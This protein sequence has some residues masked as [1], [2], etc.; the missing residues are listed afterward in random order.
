[1]SHE[2][3]HFTMGMWVFFLAYGTSVVGSYVGLSCVRQSFKDDRKNARIR[4]LAMASLAIGGVGIWLMHFIGMMGFAVPGST[5][6][7]AL[8]PTLFSVVLAVGATL[9]GL[10]IVDSRAGWKARVPRGVPL[11]VGGLVMG[12]AVSFMHYSGMAAIRIRGT[13]EHDQAF[14]VASVIIGIVASTAALWLAGV[15]E[16]L[17]ARAAAALIMGCAVVALHYTGMAGVNA[18]VDA[19]APEPG[20]QTVL[21]LLFPAF[22]IGIA[23]LALPIVALLLAPNRED[24]R[25]EAAVAQWTGED[26][27]AEAQAAP[28]MPPPTHRVDGYGTDGY[29]EKARVKIFPTGPQQRTRAGDMIGRDRQSRD[30][31]GALRP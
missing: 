18:T 23:V 7:Y 30:A 12:L 1:M 19:S 10:W 17:V 24:R 3:H 14:V 13:I 11:A 26:E 15:A 5:I 25:R 29:E 21:S 2:L 9:F 8:A 6:R 27:P 22:V 31:G 20:G 4:W 16:R 28:A